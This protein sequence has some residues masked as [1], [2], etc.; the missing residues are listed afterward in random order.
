MKKVKKKMKEK[1]WLD[2]EV[3]QLVSMCGEMHIEFEKNAK[4]MYVVKF[5]CK[6]F[7]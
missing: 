3:E 5:Y 7:L 4:K 2:S 1:N 6:F